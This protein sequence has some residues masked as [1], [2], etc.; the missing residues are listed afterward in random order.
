MLFNSLHFAVFFPVVVAVFFLLRGRFGQARWLFLLVASYYFYVSWR[1][2]YIILILVSTVVDYIA[3]R[4]IGR[5]ENETV[6]KLW[7]A[8]SLTVNLG[9]LIFFKYLVFFTESTTLF[10]QSIGLETN[11]PTVELLLPVGISFYTFQTLSYTI[12]VYRGDIEPEKDIGVFA[13]FVSFFPQLVAGPIERPSSLLPQLRNLSQVAFDYERA[14]SGLKLM[15][16][17]LFKKAVIADRLAIYVNTVYQ[18]PSD[19]P[20]LPMII[21]TVFF[22]FQIYCD[23]SGYSDIAI[24]AARVIG[25]DLRLNFNRPYLASS[26]QD[27][28]ARW[29]ISLSTWFRD[30]VYIPLGGNR[31][32]IW[33]WHFNIMATFLLSGL[34]HGANWTFV[35]WGAIH[36]G[37]YV[38]SYWGGKML[39]AVSQ[40]LTVPSLPTQLHPVRHGLK[41]LI[42]FIVVCIAWVFFRATSLDNALLIIIQMFNFSASTS[43]DLIPDLP[44]LFFDFEVYLAFLLVGYLMLVE[45]VGQW[46]DWDTFVQQRPAVIRYAMYVSLALAISLLGEFTSVSQFIYFQF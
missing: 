19:Y 22:A 26:I 28:W 5:A 44:A 29:H 8:L 41:V 23:F 32:S 6:R 12:D 35:I 3:S 18:T 38:V 11:L 24:G 37:L 42:T 20:G 16:W 30:Y 9:I 10:F 13:L 14:T 36:G 43:W 27:F 34:W 15:A 45:I 40:G 39:H 33:R 7:L 4:N 17:G 1:A 25:V 21:A 2:E 31:T 46:V